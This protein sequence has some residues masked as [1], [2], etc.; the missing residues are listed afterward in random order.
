MATMVVDHQRSNSRPSDAQAW[1][2]VETRDARYDGRF[3]YAVRSTS[4]YCRPT[5]PSRR[6]LRTN[7][8]FFDDAADAETAGYRA[9]LRCDPRAGHTGSAT[10]RAVEAA[11]AYIDRNA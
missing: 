3:V 9:C 8:E 1:A 7:V 10:A 4:V 2:A 6:P 5:C 11:R